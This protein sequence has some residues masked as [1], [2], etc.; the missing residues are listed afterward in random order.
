MKLTK[1]GFQD[2]LKTATFEQWFTLVDRYCYRLVGCSVDDLPDC[3]Y[4]DWYDAST[5][6][7]QAAKQALQEAGYQP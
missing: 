1:E 5:H 6:P 2:W 7:L 3:N 4:R